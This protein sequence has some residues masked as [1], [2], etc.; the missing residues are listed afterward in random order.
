MRP[1]FWDTSAFV[2]LVFIEPQSERASRAMAE[3]KTHHAWDWMAVEANAALMRRGAT[4]AHHALLKVHLS[5]MHWHTLPPEALDQIIHKNRDWKLRAADAGHLFCLQL[6][7]LVDRRF[8]LV[9]FDEEM[10][11]AAKSDGLAVL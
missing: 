9:S 10:C 2:S 5:R 11:R 3:G 6:L 1:V 8:Q 4:P 7:H